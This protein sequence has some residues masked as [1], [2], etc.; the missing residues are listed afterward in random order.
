MGSVFCSNASKL[1][2]GI[3]GPLLWAEVKAKVG[4]K[5]TRKTWLG[6]SRSFV[7]VA[8]SAQNKKEAPVGKILVG[9]KEVLKRA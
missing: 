4:E 9:F 6:S 8:V 3:V 1:F 5:R 2:G 7:S